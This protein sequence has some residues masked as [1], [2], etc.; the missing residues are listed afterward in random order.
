MRGSI[1]VDADDISHR[2]AAAP[3]ARDDESKGVIRN[4]R[5]VHVVGDLNRPA[6]KL[7]GNL[8]ERDDGGVSVGAV[9]RTAR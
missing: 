3:I 1:D 4:R 6:R 8:G 9:T 2:P 5:A 7:R